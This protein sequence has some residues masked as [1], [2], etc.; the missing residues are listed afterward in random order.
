MTLKAA[1]SLLLVT[2]CIIHTG[3]A[4]QCYR[5]T[6]YDSSLPD[7]K[8]TNNKACTPGNF[9]GSKLLNVSGSS[10][11]PCM[12]ITES[13]N[14]KQMTVRDGGSYYSYNTKKVSTGHI[15]RLNGYICDTNLCNKEDPSNASSIPTLLLPLLPLLVVLI[16]SVA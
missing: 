9:D 10:D 16:R 13:Y 7:N 8:I 5:C 12:A 6:G 2:L 14:N 4:F 1:V 11:S 15:Y 3:S